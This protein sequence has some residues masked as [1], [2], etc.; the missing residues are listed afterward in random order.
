VRFYVP[1]WKTIFWTEF[2]QVFTEINMLLIFSRMKLSFVCSLLKLKQLLFESK[3]KTN[4]SCTQITISSHINITGKLTLRNGEIVSP[5]ENTQ[6][7]TEHR[8][9]TED[10]GLPKRLNFQVI[11]WPYR[12]HMGY[13]DDLSE[14]LA[15]RVKVCGKQA[16]QQTSA[17]CL[18]PERRLTF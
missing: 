16:V 18:H 10:F 13:S 4:H 17:W 5:E 8:L 11:S 3:D 7:L 14:V 9:R 2:W 15:F 6:H 1:D 12:V